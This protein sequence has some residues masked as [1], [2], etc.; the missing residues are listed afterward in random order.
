MTNLCKRVRFVLFY[1]QIGGIRKVNSLTKLLQ[2][3]QSCVW[4]KSHPKYWSFLMADQTG[5]RGKLLRGWRQLAL[6]IYGK[7]DKWAQRKLYVEWRRY[8]IFQL[9]DDT[10]LLALEDRLLSFLEARSAAAEV[11]AE[12][13]ASEPKAVPPSPKT[14]LSIRKVA[15]P[16]ARRRRR[17]RSPASNAA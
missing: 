15:P 11:A 7:D 17:A 5:L 16:K 12:I 9:G 6:A 8:P 2:H 14:A 4:M 13:A 10:E 3:I 1:R